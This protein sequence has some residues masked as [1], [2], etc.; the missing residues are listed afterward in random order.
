M[1]IEKFVEKLSMEMPE[2]DLVENQY[3]NSICC[4]NLGIYLSKLFEINP[5]I[6][7]VGEAPGYRGCALT[8]VPFT[9][10]YNMMEIDNLVLGKRK[11]YAITDEKKTSYQKEG[12][13]TIIWD[14]LEQVKFMPLMWNIYPLHPHKAGNLKTN[15]TPTEIEMK[16]G[17]QY[18]DDLLDIFKTIEKIYALGRKSETHLRSHYTDREIMYIRHPA[19]GGGKMCR[20]GIKNICP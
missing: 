1:T 19:N 10:E 16:K 12:S 13:A 5:T 6:L 8:G 20:S 7:L 2:S 15:R 18:I 4:K 3:L 14:V 17:I 11:G 9:A